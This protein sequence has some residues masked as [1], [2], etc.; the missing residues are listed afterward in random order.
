MNKHGKTKQTSFGNN[1]VGNAAQR[2][3]GRLMNAALRLAP[4]PIR[5]SI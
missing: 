1:V 5:G 4:P 2:R 3:K